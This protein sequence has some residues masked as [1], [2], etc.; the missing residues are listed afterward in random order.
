MN[1]EDRE[2]LEKVVKNQKELMTALA[3]F[4]ELLTLLIEGDHD[5]DLQFDVPEIGEPGTNINIYG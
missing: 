2:L 1:E 5:M 4:S 3:R